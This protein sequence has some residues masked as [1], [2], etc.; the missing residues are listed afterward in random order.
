MVVPL[1]NQPNLAKAM[2][3]NMLVLLGGRERTEEE[4]Q[5]LVAG[6]GFRLVRVIP[7][8]SPFCVI[9]ARRT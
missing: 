6:A 3:L 2:D 4:Y 1:D 7:T 8:H 9:E 5:R